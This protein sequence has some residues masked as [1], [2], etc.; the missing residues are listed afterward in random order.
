MVS[1]VVWFA[2][3]RFTATRENAKSAVDSAKLQVGARRMLQAPQRK[4]A[5]ANVVSGIKLGTANNLV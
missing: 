5:G 2:V 4:G 3:V 1:I